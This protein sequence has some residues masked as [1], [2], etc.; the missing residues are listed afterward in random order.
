MITKVHGKIS[1]T[2]ESI[3]GHCLVIQKQKFENKDFC[4]RM[5]RLTATECVGMV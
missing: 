1:S 2:S 3:C 4:I 5:N